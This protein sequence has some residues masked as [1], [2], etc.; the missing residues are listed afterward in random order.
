MSFG[1]DTTANFLYLGIIMLVLVSTITAAY[2]YRLRQGVGHF[3]IWVGIVMVLVAGYAYRSDVSAVGRRTLAALVP[4]MVV[5][6]GASGEAAVVRGSDGHFHLSAG[7]NGATIDLMLDTGASSVVLTYR[8]AL[9]AGLDPE[10]LS[11]TA[12]VSTANGVTSAA[13]ITLDTLTIG[14]IAL[15]RVP[16][17][18]AR[19]GALTTSLLGNSVLNRLASF[20]IEGDRLVLRQ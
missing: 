1:D 9:A 7:I 10:R 3:A 16:A 14:D 13:P 8:D 15:D 4:G 19:P 18:V 6:T 12:E 2:R 11:F 17:L 20:T 5:S